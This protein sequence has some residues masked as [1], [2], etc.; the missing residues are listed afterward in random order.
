M[1]SNRP[2]PAQLKA[3]HALVAAAGAL[4][5]QKATKKLRLSTKTRLILFALSGT[6]M[7]FLHHKADAPVANLIARTRAATK[8]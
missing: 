3:S 4:V 7:T 1:S 6:A 8:S 5:M 2:T